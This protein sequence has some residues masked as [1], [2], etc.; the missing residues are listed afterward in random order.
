MSAPLAPPAP[1]APSGG[2]PGRLARLGVVQLARAAHPRRAVVTAA[3]LAVAAAISGRPLREVG[4]VL[5]TSGEIELLGRPM[6]SQAFE[7]LL[8]QH[9]QPALQPDLEPNLQP[10]LLPGRQRGHQSG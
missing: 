4:L 10:D 3:L 8:V 1:E 7:V 9:L 5:A 2:G 6:P